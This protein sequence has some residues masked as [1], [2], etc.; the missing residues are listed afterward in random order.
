MKTILA[1]KRWAAALLSVAILT[2]SPAPEAKAT[3]LIAGATEPTQTLH[4]GLNEAGWLNDAYEWTLARANDINK[5][6]ELIKNNVL[7]ESIRAFNE[8]MTA[9]QMDIS[10]VLGTVETLFQAPIDLFQGVME[11]PLSIWSTV[12]GLGDGFQGLYDQAMNTFSTIGEMQSLGQGGGDFNSMFTGNGFDGAYDFTTRMNGL[13]SS[14]NADFLSPTSVRRR[15]SELRRWTAQ[16]N[17]GAFGKDT[18]QIEL[19]QAELLAAQARVLMRGEEL[20]ALDR[21]DQVAQRVNA[22]KQ[23]EAQASGRSAETIS[24]NMSTLKF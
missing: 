21:L 19:A 15:D 17:R 4:A 12:Q 10:E 16:A 20:Q 8:L 9:I 14:V 6:S 7:T 13:R 24:W 22:L 23:A 18:V 1:R 5:L 2:L 11:M 3:G